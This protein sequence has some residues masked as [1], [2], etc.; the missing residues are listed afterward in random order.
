MPGYAAAIAIMWLSD[1]EFVGIAIDAGGVATGPLANS[2]LLALAFGASAAAG[3]E[4]PLVDALG[5]AALLA[6]APL[7][8]LMAVGV[9]VRRKK[10]HRKE[11]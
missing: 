10:L 4:D 8:S 3:G 9:L 1:E 11:S 5:L 2:F 6:L 7:L